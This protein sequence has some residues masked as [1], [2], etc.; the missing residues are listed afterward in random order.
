MVCDRMYARKT[1]NE[2]RSSTP[3]SLKM[4][5]VHRAHGSGSTCDQKCLS[6]NAISKLAR[7]QG[8]FL[9]ELFH[10]QDE[11]HRDRQP[12]VRSA[13]CIYRPASCE[14]KPGC[15]VRQ[16]PLA[17]KTR[18]FPSF[19]VAPSGSQA[20][21]MTKFRADRWECVHAFG[22]PI[23]EFSCVGRGFHQSTTRND[24]RPPSLFR[25]VKLRIPANQLRIPA[26]EPV[27]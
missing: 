23:A 10:D 21:H 9:C 11:L 19:F 12:E 20:H 14:A 18:H 7:R 26:T 16:V 17:A 6:R 24:R 3:I 1:A 8:H 25:S 22:G 27:P 15:T 4:S 2:N 13:S 5:L